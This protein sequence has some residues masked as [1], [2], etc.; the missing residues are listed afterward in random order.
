MAGLVLEIVEGPEA[1]RQL[2]LG[3]AI[4]IGRDP[5]DGLA[6]LDPEIS[7]RHARIEPG[8][9][10]ATVTDLGS[11]NGTYVNDQ[12]IEAPRTLRPGD[13]IRVGTTVVELRSDAQVAAQPSAVVAMPQVP[14]AEAVLE[15]VPERELSGAFEAPAIPGLRREQTPP[16]YVPAE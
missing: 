10:G 1:G 14:A 9:D 12:P 11:T 5:G 16:G 7:R 2:P 15:P 6:I 13:R 3:S 8:G 4:E